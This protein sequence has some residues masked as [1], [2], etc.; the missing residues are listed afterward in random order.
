MVNEKNES[1]EEKLEKGWR[2]DTPTNQNK[3]E[4]L[5]R[6]LIAIINNML[7]PSQTELVLDVAKNLARHNNI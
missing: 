5:T 2:Q 4:N 1:F 6:E 7:N 3:K